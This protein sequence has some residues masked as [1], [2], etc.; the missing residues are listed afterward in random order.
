MNQRVRICRLAAWGLSLV[1]AALAFIAWGQDYLWQL[2]DLSTYQ[3]FPLLGL[4][5]WSIM[6]SHYMAGSLAQLI[7]LSGEVLKSYYKW[8]GLAVLWLIC[9]HPG[10]LIY[11]RFRDGHGL[12][13][14]SYLSYVAPGLKW[15]VVL[16]TVSLLIFLA[17]E[18]HRWYSQRRWWHFVAEA[19]DLAMLAIFYHG[20]RLGSQL[21]QSD[22]FRTLWWF[23]GFSL[24][25]VLIRSYYIKYF[26][27]KAKPAT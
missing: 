16:G 19:G 21:S 24:I 26:K 5:A 10:L 20:L 9:L 23:Y 6:W 4:M 14:G 18:F 17:Y 1:T 7:G 3:I 15:L 27:P 2:A 25:A 11:Q 13:P 12:P 22:W 8:T